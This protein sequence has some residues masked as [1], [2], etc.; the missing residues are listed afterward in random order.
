MHHSDFIII[1][2][3]SMHTDE[4]YMYGVKEWIGVKRLPSRTSLSNLSDNNHHNKLSVKSKQKA[5]RA[6][7]YLI[8]NSSTKKAYSRK[9]GNTFSFKVNFITLT[10]ASTQLHSDKTIKQ[11]L[12]KQFLI[13]ARKKW[14]LK[15]YVWKSERQSNGNIHFHI[16]SDIWIPWLELQQVWNRIQEKLGYISNYEKI[17]HKRNPNSTDVHSLKSIKNVSA[18]LVKYMVKNQ[19]RSIHKV[20]SKIV[21]KLS[22]LGKEKL[23]LSKGAKKFLGSVS[24]NGRIWTCSYELSNIKGATSILSEEIDNEIKLLQSK[25]GSRRIDKEHFSGIFYNQSVITKEDFPHLWSLFKEY[26]KSIFPKEQQVI[27][28]SE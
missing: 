5:K 22:G 4:L 26:I 6:I 3:V 12:L 17:H 7:K 15:N 20:S 2:T 25:K 27:W 8:Y 11:V 14:G 21:P 19:S 13:E 28:N 23:S 16:L 1:P 24:S 10:L 18:Y 9:T